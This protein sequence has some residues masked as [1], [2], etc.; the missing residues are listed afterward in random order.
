MT[1]VKTTGFR[2]QQDFFTWFLIQEMEGTHTHTHEHTAGPV[3]A[4]KGT[5]R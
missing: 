2:G 4:Y 5:P 1:A 3:P